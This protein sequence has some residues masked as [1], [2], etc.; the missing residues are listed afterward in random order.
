MEERVKQKVE[1][2]FD[3]GE[4]GYAYYYP[5]DGTAGQ[6]FVTNYK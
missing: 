3:E 6:V 4:V 5:K 1:K 2:I